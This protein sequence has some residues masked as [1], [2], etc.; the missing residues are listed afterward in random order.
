MAREGG[1]ESGGHASNVFVGWHRAD[2]GVGW[3]ASEVEEFECAIADDS[4]GEVSKLVVGRDYGGVY[5]SLCGDWGEWHFAGGGVRVF[6]VLYV[7][8]CIHSRYRANLDTFTI[9]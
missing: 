8:S 2:A 4:Y 3:A 1:R 6:D 9:G 5:G 7:D